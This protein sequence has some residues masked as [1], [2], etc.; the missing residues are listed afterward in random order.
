[1]KFTRL[2]ALSLFLLLTSVSHN[3]TAAPITWD[4]ST[5]GDLDG[6][7]D[8][9]FDVGE[10]IISGNLSF[11]NTPTS[12]PESDSDKFNFTLF[13][14]LYLK[15]IT[16]EFL[17]VN[18][19]NIRYA[20]KDYLLGDEF[21]N[22]NL[23]VEEVDILNYIGPISLYDDTS[24]FPLGPGYY[25]FGDFGGGTG[26]DGRVDSFYNYDYRLTFDVSPVPEPSTFLLLGG[27]LIGLAFAV[28]RRKTE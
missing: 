16:L 9:Y 14:D 28:R 17:E 24:I 23:G 3:L 26:Y 18:T 15:S 27:G 12:T 10:N 25:I 2:I 5:N 1:M 22:I 4:E 21:A 7:Q 8:F 11:F 13:T 6:S 19:S 20:N